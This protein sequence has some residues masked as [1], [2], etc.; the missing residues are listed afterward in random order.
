MPP[1]IV[2]N[3]H[4]YTHADGIDVDVIAATITHFHLHLMTS[5][6][7]VHYY[8]GTAF[9]YKP[10]TESVA[11]WALRWMQVKR[12]LREFHFNSNLFKKIFYFLIHVWIKIES[13]PLSCKKI[14]IIVKIGKNCV[15]VFLICEFFFIFS[16]WW[17]FLFFFFFSEFLE[18]KLSKKWEKF[19]EKEK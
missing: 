1:L 7:F 9:S 3:T 16:F 12:M 10:T 15:W 2:A 4:T 13:Y 8:C 6:P 17:I 11:L 19:R 14:R 5:I 18:L